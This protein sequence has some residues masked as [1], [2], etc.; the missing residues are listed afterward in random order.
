[1]TDQASCLSHACVLLRGGEQ[2]DGVS[3]KFD[4]K[5]AKAK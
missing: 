1:M 2:V 4:L 3:K 5:A